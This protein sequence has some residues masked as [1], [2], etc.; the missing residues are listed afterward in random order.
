MMNYQIAVP[1]WKRPDH[2]SRLLWTLQRKGV[3]VTRVT[4]FLHADDPTLE[5]YEMISAAHGTGM[6]VS[7]VHGVAAQR[8]IISGHYP[9]GTS[10]L[11]MDDDVRQVIQRRPEPDNRKQLAEWDSL[12]CRMFEETEQRGLYMWGVKPT[13]NI[14][15]EAIGQVNEGLRFAIG[16]LYGFISRPG[17]PF[18]DTS[19]PVKEDYE[20]SI[21]A[22]L[23]DGGLVRFE[24]VGVDADH[25]GA[26]GGCAD[27]RTQAI[28]L[29]AAMHLLETYPTLVRWNRTRTLSTGHAEISL[30][31]KP[32]GVP[33]EDHLLPPK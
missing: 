8:K 24:D 14:Q 2:V 31:A 30:A 16:S 22:Y 10:V 23:H 3:D 33:N 17:H 21:L 4:L 11:S 9:A 18:H 26:V 19:V 25:Y 29:E 6:C 13:T 20:L 28:S 12:F 15:A 32:R 5:W 7:Q 27:W 1:T